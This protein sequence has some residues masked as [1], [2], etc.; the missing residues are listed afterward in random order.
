M[1]LV[2]L[3]QL[4]QPIAEWTLAIALSLALGTLVNGALLY[5]GAWAPELGLAVLM[6]VSLIGVVLQIHCTYRSGLLGV[7]DDGD[8]TAS[9]SEDAGNAR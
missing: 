1:S 5:A 6:G 3:L 8:N 9:N 4:G 2:R 7:T